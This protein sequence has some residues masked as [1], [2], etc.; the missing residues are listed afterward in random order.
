M[1]PILLA[2][3]AASW[4]AFSGCAHATAAPSSMSFHEAR[5]R[6]N[7]AAKLVSSL[8]MHS[9]SALL[10]HYGA[11][12]DVTA[13]WDKGC[14]TGISVTAIGKVTADR[15]TTGPSGILLAAA[16]QLLPKRSALQLAKGPAGTTVP[17]G[18]YII[19][20]TVAQGESLSTIAAKYSVSVNTIA[21]SNSIANV[22][23]LK[24]GQ[25][26]EF[27]SVS[28]VVHKVKS[29][30]TIWTIAKRYGVSRDE[31]VKANALTE[32][33][34]LA[35]NQALVVPGGKP[36]VSNSAPVQLASRGAT[37]AREQAAASGSSTAFRWPLT[38]RIS[39][40][41]GSR[42]GSTHHG[43][44][45]AVPVG[46]SVRAAASG[47][48]TFSGT[49]SGYGKIIIIDHGNGVSTRY[50]HNS[51]LLVGVGDRID[52]GDRIALSGNTGKSTGPH[53]HFEIR[54]NG[55]SV[56]PLNYLD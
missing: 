40:K 43:I 52:A 38:G 23:K 21:W 55:R 46:T 41:Y 16:Q 31:I 6:K 4:I 49:Q 39:S 26:L 47:K 24:V 13:S 14:F 42:W 15:L 33:D 3:A 56:N 51:K 2:A 48:V 30:E 50:A 37:T 28:G 18:A 1:M 44:D 8:S 7:P 20:H 32:P 11:K 53:L 36:I 10:A 54:M 9:R 12:A 5:I 45:I 34:K 19:K 29:G 25:V 22:N 27:P 17:Q 35:L